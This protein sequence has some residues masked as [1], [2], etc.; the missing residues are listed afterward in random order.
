MTSRD[1]IRCPS[2][3]D[4]CW[5]AFMLVC[6]EMVSIL[7]SGARENTADDQRGGGQIWLVLHIKINYIFAGE[8]Q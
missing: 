2:G 6:L 7:S 1:L 4:P 3:M 8:N 5:L